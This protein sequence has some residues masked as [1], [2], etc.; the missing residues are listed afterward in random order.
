MGEWSVCLRLRGRTSFLPGS[1]RKFM[2]DSS[3]VDWSTGSVQHSP[4]VLSAA[5][6]P[7]IWW[8]T[9]GTRGVCQGMAAITAT[10]CALVGGRFKQVPTLHPIARI[11]SVT[12]PVLQLFGGGGHHPRACVKGGPDTYRPGH[13][14]LELVGSLVANDQNMGCR[15]TDTA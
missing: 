15:N 7:P 5:R 9:A 8:K 1:S 4:T 2:D 10:C 3:Q 13:C 6:P 14:F 11:H 12:P